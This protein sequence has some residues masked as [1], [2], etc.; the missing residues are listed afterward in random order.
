MSVL[1]AEPPLAPAAEVMKELRRIEAASYHGRLEQLRSDYANQAQERPGDPMVQ[2]FAAW[3]NQPSDD[4]WNQLRAVSRLHPDN[5]WTHYGMGR[6]YARW[7]M[8]AQAGSELVQ[9]L[10]LDAR[11]FPAITVQGDLA[12]ARSAWPDAEALYRQALAIADDPLARAG[13]GF[14]LLKQNRKDEALTELKAST[15][16]YPEQPAAL[17]ILIPLL[18]E[19]KTRRWS[20]P[21]RRPL[22]CGPETRTRGARWP[23]SASPPATARA[24][25][26]ST[27]RCCCSAAPTH[28]RCT[29]WWGSTRRR[30][31]RRK[32]RR[33]C[34]RSACSSPPTPTR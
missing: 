24:P 28:P 20:T 16:V 6:I 7:K 21:P 11:F 30:P 29:G 2:I 22:T 10:K 4:A 9:A 19:R 31:T 26:R 34:A 5:P 25:P 27:S 18:A 8:Y 13:L 23:T 15:R 3:L 32:R 33:R 17:A 14:A 12:A 1:A